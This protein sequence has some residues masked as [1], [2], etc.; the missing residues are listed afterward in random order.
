MILID[1]GNTNI[2]FAVSNNNNK[3]IKIS[4]IDTKKETNICVEN[5][6]KIIKKLLHKNFLKNTKFAVISSVVPSINTHIIKILKIYKIKVFVLKPKDVLSY[7]KIDYNLNEIGADRIANS[8]AVVN[9]KIKNSIVIDFGTA[10]T[11]EVLKNGRFLGGLIFPGI[12][13]S[14]DTLIKKTSL[15]KNAQII[16]THKVVAKNTKDSIQSGFYWGYI[17]VIN[18]I[19]K[20]IIDEKK[21]KPKIILTGGLAKIFKNDIKPRPIVNSNL[22]LEGLQV[23]GSLYYEKNK[24]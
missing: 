8:V 13:L 2:V 17:S 19:I 4:R 22:T 18:G 1:V 15:L 11:F 23:I 5:V 14:K 6:N 21:F 16:K 10:T 3:I 12:E 20:K 7:L 9:S 24:H